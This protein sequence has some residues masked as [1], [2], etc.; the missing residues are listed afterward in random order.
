[1]LNLDIAQRHTDLPQLGTTLWHCTRCDAF[2][3]IHSNHAFEQAF[4]PACSTVALE[5]CGRLNCIP[6]ILFDDA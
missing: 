4:C 2:V 6:G 5:F 1:M 3:S